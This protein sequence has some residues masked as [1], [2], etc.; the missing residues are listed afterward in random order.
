MS[1][2]K[3]FTLRSCSQTDKSIT[4]DAP[5][6]VDFSAIID[7]LTDL[8][9]WVVANRRYIA[10]LF[11]IYFYFYYMM[12]EA[13]WLK[14]A[15]NLQILCRIIASGSPAPLGSRKLVKQAEGR[16]PMLDADE[17]LDR[18]EPRTPRI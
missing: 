5:V 1:L 7:R 2:I 16:M 12:I 9:S 11:A 15:C 6:A 14:G 17:N 3:S 13:C 18:R 4:P 10:N 8:H